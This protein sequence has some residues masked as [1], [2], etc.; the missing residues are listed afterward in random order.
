MAR[1][2]K[3]EEPIET[4]EIKKTV[5]K[6]ET[7]ENKDKDIDLKEQNSQ[8]LDLINSMKKEIDNLK[9]QQAVQPQVIVQQSA[10]GDLTRTVK[11]T[12]LIA[13]SYILST[14]PN[15]RGA[16]FRFEKYG[17]TKNIKFIEMQSVLQIYGKQFEE[18]FAVLENKKDYDD[19]G[20]GYVYD[21]VLSK[22]EFD[23]LLKLKKEEDVDKIL[24]FS[25]DMLDNVLRIIAK[26][27]INNVNYD[28]NIINKLQRETDL[29]DYIK[30]G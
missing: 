16:V 20:I 25:D 11:V 29:E 8:L 27:I 13:G 19:L 21:N 17:D 24:N 15:G 28:M 6:N 30:L 23:E 4:K 14:Q 2:K 9:S 3:A 26:N 22:K 7:V 1:P 18:G 12:S 5:A 10:N